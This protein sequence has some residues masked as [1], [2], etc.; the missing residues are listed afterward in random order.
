[1]EQL[2][3][4]IDALTEEFNW[5]VSAGDPRGTAAGLDAA[6]SLLEEQKKLLIE[7]FPEI[8]RKDLPS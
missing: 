6:L 2:L 5:E 1:M 3:K 8:Y 4:A 7:E